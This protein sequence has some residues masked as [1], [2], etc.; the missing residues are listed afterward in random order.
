MPHKK[1]LLTNKQVFQIA[2]L[3]FK[4]K[5]SNMYDTHAQAETFRN[6]QNRTEIWFTA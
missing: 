4:Y 3:L 6:P 5:R 1:Y 2:S